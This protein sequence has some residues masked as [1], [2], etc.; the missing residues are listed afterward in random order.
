MSIAIFPASGGL[1]GATLAHLLDTAKVE[2]SSLVLVARSPERLGKE[3]AQGVK[4]LKADYD[5]PETLDGVFKGVEVLNLISYASFQHKY[6][7]KVCCYQIDNIHELMLGCKSR[8]RFCDLTRSPTY[9]LLFPRIRSRWRTHV[10]TTRH[11]RSSRN[12]GILGFI[13]L[14]NFLI[15]RNPTRTLL[16]EFPSVYGELRFGKGCGKQ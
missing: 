12:G 16:R 2:P 6:R 5:H 7:F 8:Y 15:Y 1:G 14:A 3:E 11:A 9:H 13:S 10:Q 4:V